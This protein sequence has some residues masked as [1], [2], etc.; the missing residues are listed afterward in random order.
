MCSQCCSLAAQSCL[1]LC[2]PMGCSPPGSSVH[3][4]LQA[5]ILEWAAISSSKGSS[6]PKDRTRVSCASC[7][8][9]RALHP[10][11]HLGSPCAPVK[12]GQLIIIIITYSFHSESQREKRR[13]KTLSANKSQPAEEAER[14][15]RDFSRCPGPESM[16]F[17]LKQ[18][19]R[20]LS[21]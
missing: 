16:V 4:I 8:G 13:K 9:R 12:L 17:V 20:H 18:L 7:T 6:R 10:L 21:S 2:D 11:S 3:G 1:T 19:T 5:Q 14:Q 15:V